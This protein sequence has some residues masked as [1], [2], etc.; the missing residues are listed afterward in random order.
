[1]KVIFCDFTIEA[2]ENVA[3]IIVKCLFECST[4]SLYIYQ[5]VGTHQVKVLLVH[6]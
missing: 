5:D 6:K 2:S 1:M 3:N 4:Y